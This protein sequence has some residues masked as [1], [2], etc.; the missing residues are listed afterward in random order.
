[1]ATTYYALLEDEKTV[2]SKLAAEHLKEIPVPIKLIIKT[3]FVTRVENSN[4]TGN[5]YAYSAV[6]IEGNHKP[7]ELNNFLFIDLGSDWIG[8]YVNQREI[9]VQERSS[10]VI[11]K[12]PSNAGGQGFVLYEL[13]PSM[14]QLNSVGSWEMLDKLEELDKVKAENERHKSYIL[15]LED[16]IKALKEASVS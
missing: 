8:K 12:F 2:I 3:A 6:D 15:K 4:A 10:G 1:M 9:T 7:V 13:L 11:R 14:R 5:L 16:Q